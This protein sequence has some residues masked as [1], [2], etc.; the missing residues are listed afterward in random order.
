M[1]LLDLFC[2]AGGAAMGYARAGFTDIVG[3]DIAFQPHYPFSFVLGDALEYL[4]EHGSEFDA[5]HASPPCQ[6]WTRVGNHSRDSGAEYPD[7]LT[8]L[9]PILFANGKPFVIENVPGAPLVDP[10]LLCGSMF[11][12]PLH[13]RRHRLFEASFPIESPMWA[14]RH[15]LYGPRFP[16]YE[17]YRKRLSSTA[18]A[19]GNNTYGAAEAMGIDW[20]SRAELTQAIPPAY[21]EFVGRALLATLS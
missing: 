3:V 17:H 10:L 7:C 6:L 8:P 18:R 15:G 12:P 20:M 21:T 4:A 5:I 19:H 9:R 14:C 16:I 2:G 13:V 11:D 1:R